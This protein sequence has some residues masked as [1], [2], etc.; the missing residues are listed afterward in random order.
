MSERTNGEITVINER[1]YNEHEELVADV[2]VFFDNRARQEERST[3]RPLLE[4]LRTPERRGTQRGCCERE[5]VA[6]V[7]NWTLPRRSRRIG[8]KGVFETHR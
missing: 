3:P 6:I 4:H 1:L 5:E 7:P 8:R 2:V